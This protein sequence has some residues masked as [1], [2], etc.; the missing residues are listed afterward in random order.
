MLLSIRIKRNID[1]LQLLKRAPPKLRR[2][3]LE[4]C[5]RDL[6]LALCE[7]ALNTLNGTVKLSPKRRK[8]LA[9]HGRSLRAVVDGKVPIAKKRRLLV[10]QGGFLASLLV[11]ALSLLAS[12]LAP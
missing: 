1:A 12:L 5:D 3:I 9:R 2:A 6:L 7:I 10:Q 8:S 4:N 11:P